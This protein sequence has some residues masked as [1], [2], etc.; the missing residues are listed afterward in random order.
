MKRFKLTQGQLED[1]KDIL[2]EMREGIRTTYFTS[3]EDFKL[4]LLDLVN[5]IEDAILDLLKEKE[6]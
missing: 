4:T 2:E 1:L 3:L 6:K 5:G